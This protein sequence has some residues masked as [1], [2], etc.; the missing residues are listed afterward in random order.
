MDWK[1]GVALLLFLPVAAAVRALCNEYSLRKYP[2]G[3]Y[4]RRG[5]GRRRGDGA[6][7]NEVDIDDQPPPEVETVW[8]VHTPNAD[9]PTAAPPRVK[10]PRSNEDTKRV[11]G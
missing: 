11:V 2:R 6:Q 8:D 4:D 1:V 10:T 5:G 3:A 7:G 9:A